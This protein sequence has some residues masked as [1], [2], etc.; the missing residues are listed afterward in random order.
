MGLSA[1]PPTRAPSQRQP[2]R[3]HGCLAAPVARPQSSPAA[4]LPPCPPAAPT[5]GRAIHRLRGGFLSMNARVFMNRRRRGPLV[6]RPRSPPRAPAGRASAPGGAGGERPTH[7]ARG[8]GR[9]LGGDEPGGQRA[10][11]VAGGGKKKHLLEEQGDLYFHRVWV[12]ESSCTARRLAHVQHAVPLHPR[13]EQVGHSK[14][15]LPDLDGSDTRQR[16]R[17]ELVLRSLFPPHPFQ[18]LTQ[19]LLGP[20]TAAV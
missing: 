18:S 5:P 19:D 10:G 14:W 3:G 17:V 13:A 16:A 8:N 2:Q 7:G 1:P 11:G 15:L 6:A 12:T 4:A 9:G 20:V